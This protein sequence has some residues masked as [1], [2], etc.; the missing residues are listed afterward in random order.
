MALT[1]GTVARGAEPT[2]CYFAA[3]L[4]VCT[5]I[6]KNYLAHARVLAR[7]LREHDPDARMWTLVIDDYAG[8]IDP[9]REPFELLSPDDIGC[10]PFTHMALRYSVLELSTAVKPWLLRHLM[11]KT[12]EPVTY[13]DPDI[14]IYRSISALAEL[15]RRHGVALIPHNS[16]PIPAD[17]RQPSQVDIMIAGVF[18]LGYVTL[19]PGEEV[20]HLLDWWSDRLRRDCRVDP[21]WG[22]FVDQRWF[23]LAPAFLTDLAIIRD[24]EYNVAYWNLHGR[25]LDHVD[26]RYLVNGRP[27]AFF[28]FS[29]FDPER[30][31]VLS[32]HQNRVDVAD[33]PVLERILS[34]YADEVM[35]EGHGVSR[36]WPYTYSA[37]GDGTRVDATLRDLYDIYV[38]ER[39]ENVPS[40][41]TV[42]GVRAFD[43]WL[44]ENPSG[45]PVGVNR[46]LARI[47][48]D[49]P[50][51]QQAYPEVALGEREGL[52]RWAE[53]YGRRDDPLLDRVMAAANGS[54]T[55]QQ[56]RASSGQ[57]FMRPRDTHKPEPPL[58][59]ARWGVNVVGYF[60]SELGVGEVARQVVRALDAESVPVLPLH[61]RTVPLSRQGHAYVTADPS[62]ASFGLNLICM[63]ADMLPEFARQAGDEF[64]VGRYSIGLWFWEVTTF[65][66]RWHDS[67]SL[68]EEVWAPTAHVAKALEPVASVPVTTVRVPVAPPTLGS[69]HR[70]DLGLPEDKFLFL[71]SFDYLSVFKRKNPIAVVEAF[72]RSFAP[73]EGAALVLKCINDE[74][75]PAAHAK[76]CA[77]AAGHPDIQVIDRYLSPE[78]CN[79]LI[80][81][82]DS[83]VSL[84]RSEGFGLGMAEAMALGKPV[85]A[86][87]YSGNLDFMTAENSLLVDHRLV[88]IG[89]GAGPYPA[90]GNWAEP[91]VEH[92]ATLMRSLFEDREWAREL[93]ARAAADIVRTH[94]PA[95][96]GKIMRRRLEAIWGTGKPRRGMPGR[97]HEPPS[98]AALPVRIRRGPVPRAGSP[99]ATLRDPARR[100]LLRLI[101]PFT[102]YQQTVNT[103]ILASL[104][105]LSASVSKLR[106][107]I[108][109]EQAELLRELRGYAEL[110]RVPSQLERQERAIGELERKVDELESRMDTEP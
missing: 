83:Y 38:E 63:N 70:G 52:L 25:R 101:R 82:C 78:D 12:G 57:R 48:E 99:G 87:G 62:D 16:E 68:V 15:G 103:E 8:F 95:A 75:D 36:Q 14:K 49:R 37:L 20:D 54:G 21:R 30:P 98:L 35:R 18:N 4:E 45:A 79:S 28:H 44:Q 90:E 88:D 110:E 17:D 80:S 58:S 1:A 61:G 100:A 106:R 66:E 74:H 67:F 102:A 24:P 6:A 85:V 64:F 109:G 92:A 94:S 27:L 65:P 107:E 105:D 23:D 72:R 5:I 50:D 22:Y 91:D 56:V 40:P 59:Q 34:E 77:S 89:D 7:S 69:S 53:E 43:A 51:L 86:T 46:V 26:G 104:Q 93:G 29:G 9:A 108:V 73:G 96:A 33:D 31:L 2:Q 60:R 39:G 76:L 13:L 47:Y 42:G 97:A 3:A 81:L 71:F 11:G 84:H 41:F 19:A 55:P 32:K 10:E